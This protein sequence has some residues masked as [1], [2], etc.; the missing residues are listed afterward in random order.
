[1]STIASRHAG[2]TTYQIKTSKIVPVLI[3]VTMIS[4][5]LLNPGIAATVAAWLPESAKGF[6][7][8]LPMFST[9][10]SVGSWMRAT[11]AKKGMC[12]P[13]PRTWRLRDSVC[14]PD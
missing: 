9:A 5:S 4:C 7:I 12:C 8:V 10:G 14:I 1:M 2:A 11:K 6:N 3:A 13:W